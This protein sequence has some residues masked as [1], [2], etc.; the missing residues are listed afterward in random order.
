MAMRG[1]NDDSVADLLQWC[2]DRGYEL[3]FIEQMPL[4]AQHGWDASTMISAD[5]IRERLG[6]RFT[7]DPP[8]RPIAA[9]R[10][11]S[12]S[13]STVDRDRGHHRQRPRRRSALPATA[14]G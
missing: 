8:A 9:A 7:L 14:P 5:E 4:D 13:A 3:R 11:R 1:I 6:E 10:R 12:G 2:L